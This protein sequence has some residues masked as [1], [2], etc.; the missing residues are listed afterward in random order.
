MLL[1]IGDDNSDRHLTPYIT[2]LLILANIFVF[3]FLQGFGSNTAF[4]YAFSTVPAEILTNHDIVTAGKKVLIDGQY[5]F[6]P[7]LQP[8]PIPVFLTIVSSMFMHGSFAHIAGNMLYLWI[9]GDNLESRMGHIRYLVFY[10]LC[11]VIA[12]LSH[13]AFTAFTGADPLTPSLGASGAISGVLGGYLLLYPTRRV[14][15]LLGWFIIY[16]PSWIAL[17]M[18]IVLQL[19]S[20]FGA[21]AGQSDGVAYAAHVGGFIAGFLLVK[22]FDKGETKAAPAPQKWVQRR[23]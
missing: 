3:V 14:K 16:I 21:I 18:W 7:G 1:P 6:V 12:A 10:L 8:T 11:G 9:F 5:Y 4:T 17:G 15:A 2:W 22:F 19:V 20:G 13:V 23:W